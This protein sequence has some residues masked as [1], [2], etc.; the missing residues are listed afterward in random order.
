MHTYADGSV[1]LKPDEVAA[2]AKVIELGR[3][4][5]EQ[6]GAGLQH[7]NSTTVEYNLLT[8]LDLLEEMGISPTELTEKLDSHLKP[9]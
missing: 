7:A 1:T 6:L 8:A 2:V 5:A 3:E 9:R 4:L